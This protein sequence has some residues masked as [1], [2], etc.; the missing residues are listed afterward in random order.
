[1]SGKLRILP[2]GGLGEIGKNMTVVEYDG[3]IVVVDA[4]AKAPFNREVKHHEPLCARREDRCERRFITGVECPR[5]H[6]FAA[7][8]HR[9]R[10]PGDDV[11]AGAAVARPLLRHRH[12]PRRLALR[13]GPGEYGRDSLVFLRAQ[14]RQGRS[15]GTAGR[16]QSSADN[17]L[18]RFVLSRLGA[19]DGPRYRRRVHN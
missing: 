8:K 1:M 13:R 10:D 18:E 2:L 11:D 6:E 5:R 3:R 4:D 15:C 16:V 14:S 19:T 17:S 12:E 9:A 7:Q